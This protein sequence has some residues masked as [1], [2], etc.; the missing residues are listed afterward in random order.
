MEQLKN[1]PENPLDK[2]SYIS[3]IDQ[4]F[5]ELKQ[6]YPDRVE[7]C[8]QEITENDINNRVD[9][10]QNRAPK[11]LAKVLDG[12]TIGQMKD[13][14]IKDLIVDNIILPKDEKDHEEEI[15]KLGGKITG[16][17]TMTLEKIIDKIFGQE[18]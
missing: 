15:K 9:F 17:K 3:N 7:K 11:E 13:F 6:K 14:A 5:S 2:T 4:K 18:K 12:I 10:F 16:E 8:R 1:Y